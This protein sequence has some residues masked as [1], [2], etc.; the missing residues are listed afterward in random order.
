MEII[1]SYLVKTVNGVTY[2]HKVA[3][4]MWFI[5]IICAT[6]SC[7][8]TVPERISYEKACEY[9]K[10]TREYFNEVN[11]VNKPKLTG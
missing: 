3:G 7:F 11:K 9:M 1:K 6:G 4:D 8:T 5:D 2:M 10:F